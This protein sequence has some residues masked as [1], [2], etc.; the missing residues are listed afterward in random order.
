MR[1]DERPAR[2]RTRETRRYRGRAKVSAAASA[3]TT[4]STSGQPNQQ[5][6]DT[7]QPQ[8]QQQQQQQQPSCTT[9]DCTRT[10]TFRPLISSDGDFLCDACYRQSFPATAMVEEAA[11]VEAGFSGVTAN[12]SAPPAATR[13]V[14]G[15]RRQV[16]SAVRV[17][18]DVLADVEAR[19]HQQEREEEECRMCLDPGILRRCCNRYYCHRCYYVRIGPQCPGC[20]RAAH[21]TG[22]GSRSNQLPSD[23]GRLSVAVTWLLTLITAL[24]LVLGATA[25]Y[26]NWR[27]APATV[28]GHGMGT[29][30]PWMVSQM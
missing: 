16:D 9:L 27:T 19:H 6:G 20:G 21:L 10:A 4:S 3:T 7:S 17:A 2:E 22:I 15:V 8:Q 18:S 30:L 24:L 11:A 14:K 12:A 28:W 5:E 29:T 23:P 26:I 13:I 1:G 25:S